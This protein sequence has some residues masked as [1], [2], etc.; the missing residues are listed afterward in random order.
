MLFDLGRQVYLR[1]DIF[2]GFSHLKY[3]YG[4]V[5]LRPLG[6]FLEMQT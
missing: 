1:V 4:P 6:G 3:G 2:L 5:A